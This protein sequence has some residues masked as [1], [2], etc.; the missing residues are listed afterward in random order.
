MWTVAHCHRGSG[1]LGIRKISV[2]TRLIGLQ[3]F[4]ALLPPFVMTELRVANVNMT[5][6]SCF[7]MQVVTI[8]MLNLKQIRYQSTE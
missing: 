3:T 5:D 4:V 8:K 2:R 7:L 1:I 6:L